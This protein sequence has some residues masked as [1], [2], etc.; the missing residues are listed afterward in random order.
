MTTMTKTA[1]IAHARRTVSALY[2]F[3]DGYRYTIADPNRRA[4]YETHPRPYHAAAAARRADLITAAR[5]A[6]D[7]PEIDPATMDGGRWTD[8]LS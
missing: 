4:A 8:A 3:G 2:P 1:A 5:A 6:L 7:L